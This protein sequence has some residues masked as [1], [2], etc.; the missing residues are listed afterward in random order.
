MASNAQTLDTLDAAD[1]FTGLDVLILVDQSGSMGGGEYG[2]PARVASDPTEARFYAMSIIM[3]I[4]G[5]FRQYVIPDSTIRMSI[6]AFG[7]PQRSILLDWVA[8]GGD[9]EDEWLIQ[10]D[11]LDRILQP[12]Y[13]GQRNFGYT[14]VEDTFDLAARHFQ[15]LG[16]PGPD[17]RNRRV[18]IMITD[19]EPCQLE[20]IIAV[21]GPQATYPFNICQSSSMLPF[22]RAQLFNSAERIV[23][24]FLPT[25]TY[26][27]FTIVIDDKD[28][29]FY[30]TYR[31][32]WEA[33]LN[34][35]GRAIVTTPEEDGQEIAKKLQE[36]ILELLDFTS[37]GFRRES[38]DM[39]DGV[40]VFE[41]L[42]YTPRMTLNV[43]KEFDD[44]ANAG[45]VG[46][47]IIKL[48]A[49]TITRDPNCDGQELFATDTNINA[50]NV[51]P[52]YDIWELRF[53]CAGTDWRV[54]VNQGVAANANVQVEID[55]T[56]VTLQE[57][58]QQPTDNAQIY[59]WQSVPLEILFRYPTGPDS[60]TLVAT[61]DYDTYP[62]DVEARYQDPN[63]A[64]ETLSLGRSPGDPSFDRIFI[65]E[66]VGDY[67]FDFRVI[68]N[69]TQPLPGETTNFELLNTRTDPNKFSFTA[70]RVDYD[71]QFDPRLAQQNDEFLELT[72]FH[73]CVIVKDADTGALVP[74]L[75]DLTVTVD[76]IDPVGQV[77]QSEV[78]PFVAQTS[79]AGNTLI[80]RGERFPNDPDS[81][82]CNFFGTFQ[83]PTPG[84][85][86]VTTRGEL[87]PENIIVFEEERLDLNGQPAPITI[88][89]IQRI[90]L[91]MVEPPANGRVATYGPDFP[92][93]A[94]PLRVEVRVI[95]QSG[96]VEDLVALTGQSN[97]IELQ[98][99]RG[100]TNVTRPG[101]RLILR[102]QSYVFE[103]DE[104]GPGNYVVNITGAPIIADGVTYKLN[105][106][107]VAIGNITSRVVERY[108]PWT[109]LYPIVGV[110]AF[111]L[112]LIVSISVWWQRRQ[113][114]TANAP[115]N[116]ISVIREYTSAETLGAFV[117][118]KHIPDI[119]LSQY[120][121]N[122][123]SIPGKRFNLPSDAKLAR[124]EFTTF[125]EEEV[126]ARDR[127]FV[128]IHF[129]SGDPLS[130]MLDPGSRVLIWKD[131]VGLTKDHYWLESEDQQQS[132]RPDF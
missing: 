72:D 67:I 128:N 106:Q 111:I 60:G 19:G 66:E 31:D 86:T 124:V 21:E 119:D 55:L 11:D 82:E 78:I 46:L 18:I 53:P 8:L 14:G 42:P 28:T 56:Q 16:P 116:L 69:P 100:E 93:R 38:L 98:I 32:G 117:E 7:D 91:D 33:I 103:S 36:L 92:Y 125:G 17:E 99:L 3:R 129:Q 43:F 97:P 73:V 12:G 9:T 27:L 81:D 23:D 47:E 26:T 115:T 122:R 61:Q 29:P 13:F 25:E 35:N 131:E 30:P 74:H 22:N 51:G 96:Q 24:P 126:A 110:I 114:A 63:N 20:D 105:D 90:E 113:S 39:T 58:V 71:I 15:Q 68:Y 109:L 2:Q 52:N 84:E 50:V 62:L 64:I 37:S 40:D 45:S 48:Y 130:Y 107:G 123:I 10:R 120:S 79:T 65:P 76:F 57:A 102:G 118:R 85:Y 104:Y 112:L 121:R 6:I 132:G 5:D 94:N 75:D 4:L 95:D 41:V 1:D 88:N 34:P 59:Q 101:D 44:A 77:K 127:V 83:P 49:P 89:A 87:G 80:T 108:R 70:R 54:E